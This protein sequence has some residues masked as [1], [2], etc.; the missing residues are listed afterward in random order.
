MAQLF[1]AYLTQKMAPELVAG[2]YDSEQEL[3]VGDNQLQGA[4]R[5][6]VNTTTYVNTVRATFTGGGLDSDKTPD[7]DRDS[8]THYDSDNP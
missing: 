4:T 6:N 8:D 1:A 2:E 3:W 7:T 5:T